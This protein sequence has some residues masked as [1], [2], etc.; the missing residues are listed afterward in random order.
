M[1]E[2]SYTNDRLF[3]IGKIVEIVKTVKIV[4]VVEVVETVNSS[5]TPFLT[6]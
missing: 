4:E 3:A 2:I 5:L 1:V 6:I